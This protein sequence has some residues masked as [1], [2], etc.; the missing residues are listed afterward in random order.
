MLS[1]GSIITYDGVYFTMS[2]SKLWKKKSNN[3][4]YTYNWA[5][6]KGLAIFNEIDRLLQKEKKKDDELF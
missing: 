6:E 4:R 1:D 2:L 3:I 5:K